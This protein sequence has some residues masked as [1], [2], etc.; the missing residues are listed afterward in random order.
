MFAYLGWV[1][2]CGLLYIYMTN[3][4]DNRVEFGVRDIWLVCVFGA[5][6]WFGIVGIGIMA[7][8]IHFFENKSQRVIFNLKTWVDTKARWVSKEFGF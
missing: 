7:A 8:I 4:L 3:K 6:G 1:V 2:I 5:L